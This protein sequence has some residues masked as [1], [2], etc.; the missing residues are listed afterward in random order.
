MLR[1]KI[2][3]GGAL[4]LFILAPGFSQTDE[5]TEESVPNSYSRKEMFDRT[6]AISALSGGIGAFYVTNPSPAYQVDVE[7]AYLDP[8][9]LPADITLLTGERYELPARYR[10]IDQAFEV[11]LE[12]QAFDLENGKL[13][14]ISIGGRD[15][16]RTID[17]LRP[18]SGETI[19]QVHYRN[20]SI[21]LL[22][23]HLAMWQDPPRKNMFDTS[24]S[25]RTIHRDSKLILRKQNQNV[26][27]KKPKD[28]YRALD[29]PKKGALA[30]FIRDRDLN[31]RRPADIVVLLEELARR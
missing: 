27:L 6:D 24:Q 8:A 3:M 26:E 19:Y 30:N 5:R 10:I 4:L 21:Q 7:K 16:L 29:I 1:Y 18:Q 31:L 28:V 13:L 20:E 2:G 12:Q 15:F 25:F 9:Y 11:Q 22:E 17:L 23:Q 14:R